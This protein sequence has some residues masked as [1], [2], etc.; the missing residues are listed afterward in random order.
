MNDTIYIMIGPGQAFFTPPPDPV[1]PP[2]ISVGITAIAYG[3]PPPPKKLIPLQVERVETP[4]LR[5]SYSGS[6]TRDSFEIILNEI[7]FVNIFLLFTT[8]LSFELYIRN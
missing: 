8:T 1:T 2:V 7:S 6:P 3:N 5:V 4:V